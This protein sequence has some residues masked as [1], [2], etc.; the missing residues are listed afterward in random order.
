[1]KSYK[2]ADKEACCLLWNLNIYY[3]VHN[4]LQL[5]PVLG[6]M[7]PVHTL[8]M[9][10]CKIKCNV[11][12]HSANRSL[13]WS[14]HLY[15]LTACITIGTEELCYSPFGCYKMTHPWTDESL[16]PVSYVPEPPE[17]VN[18]KYCLYTRNR[19]DICQVSTQLSFSACPQGLSSPI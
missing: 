4:R 2:S 8:T 10:F 1:M 13:A 16:R 15:I 7:N 19:Q 18:P 5:G 14:V 3:S 11:F 17:K 12:L 9:Y 6:Q